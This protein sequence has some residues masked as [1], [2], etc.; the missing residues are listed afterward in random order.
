MAHRY[1]ALLKK[2]DTGKLQNQISKLE[3]K[4]VVSE[5]EKAKFQ[6]RLQYAETKE[7]EAETT[8]NSLKSALKEE[9]KRGDELKKSHEQALEGAGASTVEAFRRSETFTRDLG[10]LI[11]PSFMF[12]Y[13][14]AVDEAA[15]HLSY[16]ALE[17]LQN[18]ANYHE[19][20]KELCDP[21]AEGFQAGRNL[22]EV[23]DEFNKWLSEL[24]EV[25]EEDGGEEA[26]GDVGEKIG[27]EHEGGG[28]FHPGGEETGEKAA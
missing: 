21:M 27:K 18:T 2:Q 15:A 19:D 14:S 7:E 3:K 17:S 13:T 16:E 22:A 20:S 10:Q 6:R 25:F 8:I 4:L 26:G 23:R 5:S 28:E 12:G 11:M 1:C 24:N 9:Q